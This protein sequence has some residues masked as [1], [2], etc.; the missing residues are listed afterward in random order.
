[1]TLAEALQHPPSTVDAQLYAAMIY[2]L[3]REPK[4]VLELTERI[5]ESSIE[6]GMSAWKL[7]GEILRG[8]ALGALGESDGLEM[9]GIRLE[10]RKATANRLRQAYYLTLYADL[11]SRTGQSSTALKVISEAHSMLE[12]TG[13]RRWEP[14]VHVVHGDVRRICGDDNQAERHYQLGLETARRRGT[15]S[16][17]LMGTVR[18]ARLLREQGS[19]EDARELLAPVYGW[20]TEGF[21]TPDLREAKALLDELS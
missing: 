11:L 18:L 12:E 7:N 4:R 16:F 14:L 13:E 5:V 21:D 10:A 17:E 6:H 8:W 20:F 15:R 2:Q 3:R 19:M 1:L 9:M